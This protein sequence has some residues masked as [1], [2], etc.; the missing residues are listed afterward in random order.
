MDPSAYMERK[1]WL[2]MLSE[3]DLE[4]VSLRDHRY[5]VVIHLVTAA[6]GAEAFYTLENNATRTEGLELASKLDSAVMNAWVGKC[7]YG[8]NIIR[9]CIL[10]SY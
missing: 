4:E 9:P 7:F 2:K 1:D 8:T 6:K 5:D 3:M 10:A